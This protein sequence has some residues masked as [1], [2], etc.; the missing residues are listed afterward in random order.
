MKDMACI[1]FLEIELYYNKKL[2]QNVVP[3]PLTREDEKALFIIFSDAGYVNF[4]NTSHFFHVSESNLIIFI[5]NAMPI[6]YGSFFGHKMLNISDKI[7]K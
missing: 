7:L 1:H 3:L 2:R 5:V 6:A 4:C